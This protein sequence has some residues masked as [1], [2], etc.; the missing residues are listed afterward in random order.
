MKSNIQTLFLK[1]AENVNSPE[2]NPRAD[3][4]LFDNDY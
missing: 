4:L 1:I 3:T 2:K